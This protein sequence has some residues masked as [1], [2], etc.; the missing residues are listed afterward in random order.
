MNPQDVMEDAEIILEYAVEQFIMQK[1]ELFGV[2]KKPKLNVKIMVHG[3]SLG[4]M[5]ASYVSMKSNSGLIGARNIPVDFAYIDRTFSSLDNV[6]Y[7][8]SGI[9]TLLSSF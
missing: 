3:E 5:V 8:S 6:A 7:W 9:I 4:G 2:G 1:S